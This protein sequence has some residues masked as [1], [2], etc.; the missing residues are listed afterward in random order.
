MV[1]PRYKEKQVGPRVWSIYLVTNSVNGK[2]YVGQTVKAPETRF[3]EHR[4]AAEKGEGYLLHTAIRKYGVEAFRFQVIETCDSRARANDLERRWIRLCD[5]RSRNRGYNITSGGDGLPDLPRTPEHCARI[6][7]ALKGRKPTQ[8]AIETSRRVHTGNK[9]NLGRPMTEYTKQR[10]L[11]SNL[12]RARSK[13]ER[14][15]QS[16]AMTGRVRSEE[17]CRNISLAQKGKSKS[18]EHVESIRAAAAARRGIPGVKHT[19][20]M[21]AKLSI[22]AKAREARKRRQRQQRL[23]IEFVQKEVLSWLQG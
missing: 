18:P 20:E 13:E 8:H 2:R 6:S 11:E 10:L 4:H 7:E 22:F 21:K 17:H 14:K 3:W 16:E 12:G 5:S 23:A 15:R 9:Y 19:E 1:R